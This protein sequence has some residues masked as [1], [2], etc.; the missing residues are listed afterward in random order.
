M[1]IAILDSYAMNP[2]DLSWEGFERLGD[3]YRYETSTR[4]EAIE[5]AKGMDALVINKIVLGKDEMEMLPDLRYIGVTATGYNVVDIGEASRRKIAVTNIPYY[6]TSSVAE[7][8]FALLLEYSRQTGLYARKVKE[9]AWQK[10][11]T[12]TFQ[13]G[14]SFELAGRT[15][16]IVGLGDI[17]SKVASIAEAFDMDVVYTSHSPKEIGKKHGWQFMPL[18]ELLEKS[19]VVSLH[20]PLT[21]ETEKMIDKDALSLM[22]KDAILVN[23]ARGGLIDEDALFD[24]LSTSRIAA[25]LLDVIGEEPPRNGCRLFEL[26]NCIATPHQAWATKQART[27]L[28]EMAAKNL[29]AFIAGKSLNRIV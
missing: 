11:R 7:H 29:E 27:R 12:F 24:A 19:D 10:A 1:K 16:G 22:K 21:T 17:G 5:R 15:I 6:S 13:L 20:V 25:A 9:G 18:D 23:T 2:G 8:V 4:E 14:T 26:D 28:M 3:V